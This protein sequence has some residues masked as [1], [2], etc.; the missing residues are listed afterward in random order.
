MA[1]KDLSQQVTAT[2]KMLRLGLAVMA[3]GLPP[4]LWIGGHVLGDLPL[5]GS[6]SA[7]YHASDPVHP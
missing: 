4:L 3:F 7:Y 1:S 5:A 2:Y 6:M